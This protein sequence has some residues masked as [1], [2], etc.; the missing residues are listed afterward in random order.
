MVSD[1]EV[2]SR[3]AALSCWH[4]DVL[5]ASG[6]FVRERSLMYLSVGYRK[7]GRPT[8]AA[9]SQCLPILDRA[10]VT[11]T[12]CLIFGSRRGKPMGAGNTV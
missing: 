1:V 5:L 12:S 4:R 3:S 7:Q 2:P 11:C 6:A 10:A 8:S 9:R